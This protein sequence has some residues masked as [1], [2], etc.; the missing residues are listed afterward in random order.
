L[1]PFIAACFI[2]KYKSTAVLKSGNFV[3]PVFRK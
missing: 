1:C 3:Q 2:F